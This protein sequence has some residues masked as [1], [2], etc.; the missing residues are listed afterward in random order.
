[1]TMELWELPTHHW[2][3][4]EAT[5]SLS[6]VFNIWI[7]TAELLDVV[8]RALTLVFLLCVFVWP[9]ETGPCSIAQCLR[10]WS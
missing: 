2:M 4:D 6:L 9:F 3:R 5:I 1:M 7:M 10:N 8:L